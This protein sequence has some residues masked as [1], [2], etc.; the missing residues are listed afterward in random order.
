MSPISR[1]LKGGRKRAFFARG[2]EEGGGPDLHQ[3]ALRQSFLA[4][5]GGEPAPPAGASQ[6]DVVAGGG[7]G[8]AAPIAASAVLQG[9]AVYSS[10]VRTR[11]GDASSAP[12]VDSVARIAERSAVVEGG[13]GPVGKLSMPRGILSPLSPSARKNQQARVGARGQLG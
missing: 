10:P 11:A 8:E 7:E 1:L 6:M 3:R 12:A 9:I 4:A 2:G 13:E 5:S